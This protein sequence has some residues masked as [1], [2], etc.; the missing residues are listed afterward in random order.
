MGAVGRDAIAIFFAKHAQA[1]PAHHWMFAIDIEATYEEMKT[2][3]ANIVDDI[4]NKPRNL[5]QF[6]IED[7]DGHRFNFH[8]DL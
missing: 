7:L 2:R 8:H 4:E 5:R 3:G 6:T 1:A